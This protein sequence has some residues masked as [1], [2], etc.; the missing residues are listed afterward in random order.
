MIMFSND[1]YVGICVYTYTTITI[2]NSIITIHVENLKSE[3]HPHTS[4]KK[5]YLPIELKGT[6]NI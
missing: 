2:T 6:F 1:L 4:G 3:M 5:Q